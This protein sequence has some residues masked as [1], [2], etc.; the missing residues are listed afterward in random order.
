MKPFPPVTKTMS[1]VLLE[2][3]GV[4]KVVGRGWLEFNLLMMLLSNTEEKPI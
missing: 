2:S 1:V 4:W 3:I